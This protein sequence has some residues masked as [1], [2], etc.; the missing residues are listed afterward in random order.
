MF[1]FFNSFIF[2]S[3]GRGAQMRIDDEHK[4]IAR[5]AAR[6]AEVQSVSI[7]FIYLFVIIAIF[8]CGNAIS[9]T[10]ILVPSWLL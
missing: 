2:I 3:P 9:V 4:L 5:Y 6:L 1:N 10:E 7:F 8:L